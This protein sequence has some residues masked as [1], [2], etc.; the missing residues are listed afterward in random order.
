M[1]SLDKLI[2]VKNIRKLID[3]LNK[4]TELYDKGTPEV[5]DKEWDDAYFRLEQ[6]EKETGVIYPDSPTQSIFYGKILELNKVNH[7]HSML[8]LDKTKDIEA[9]KNFINAEA[10]LMLKLD[11]LT[12]SLKYIDGKL[13]SAETRGNGEVGE[14]ILHNAMVINNIPHEIPYKE[15]L[16][17]DGEVLCPTDYF[18]KHFSNIYKNPRNYAAGALRR[19]NSQENKNSGLKFVAWDCIK[20]YDKS[21]TRLSDKLVFLEKLGF[22]IVS[23]LLSPCKKELEKD[24]DYLKKIAQSAQYPIDGMVLKYDNC[25]YYESLGRT[26]HHFKGGLA[27]KFYDEEYETR[28]KYIDYDVSRTG[29]L[30]PVAVF[31]SID[32]DGSVCERASLHNMS[33]MEEVLGATPYCGERIWVFKA[34]M[35]IPQISRAEKKDY[36]D[37]VSHGGVTTGLGGDY[38]ILC[39]I[40][41]SPTSIIKS[42]TGVKVLYCENEQC[43]GKLAQRIDYFAGKSGLDIKGLS[44]KTIEKLIDW[45]WVNSIKDIFLLHSHQMEWMNQEGFG[46]ASVFK[47]LDA[48]DEAK[49][50]VDLA[51]FIAALGIP[52][53]GKTVAKEIV[54]YY[55]TWEDFRAAVGGDW[56]AFKGFGDRMSEELNEFDYSEADELINFINIQS[57]EEK[58]VST[59]ADGLTFCITGK[60]TSGNWKNRDE[61]KEYIENI[62][63]KVVG[64]MSSKVNYLINNDDTS[65][66]AKNVSAKKSGIPIITEA[67]FIELFGQKG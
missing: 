24:I 35:I 64:S 16:V 15:E 41:G 65:A 37:I 7:N 39:P 8:S 11:G 3:S 62:G 38:G 4:W 26:E 63:G 13:V 22:S 31:E 55:T 17:I 53:I 67:K 20:G 49:E 66:S 50:N 10:I 14:D 33:V 57:P 52:L 6:L 34:N 44:R 60:L 61:L 9:F 45:G 2:A 56:T 1:A 27:F 58:S 5:T 48:I 25:E 18:E 59:T 51:S 43:E 19:L 23:F 29:I 12:V 28:L 32:I 30:T 46:K 21:C 54:K 36:G 47:I 42:D 40:C